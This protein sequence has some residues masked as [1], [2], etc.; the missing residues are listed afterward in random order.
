MKK[1]EQKKGEIVIYQSGKDVL[2]DVVFENETVW[3]SLNQIAKLFGR[4]KS[5]ISRHLTYIFREN[6]LDKKSVVA[7]NATTASDGK[8]YQ[9]EYYNLDAI[10]SVGYRVSS[11]QATQFRV[12]A[13]SVLRDHVLKGYTINEKRIKEN[14]ALKLKELEK[15]VSLLQG[16][17]RSRALNQAQTEGLLSVITDYASSWVLLQQY[18][19]G[20]T[21]IKK[22]KT[23]GISTIEEEESIEVILAL[24]NHL[25]KKKES[26]DIFG[27]ERQKGAIGGILQSIRQS[28]GGKEVY[29][30][31]EEKA[32]HLLYFIIKQHPLIDGNKRVASLLFIFFL[33]KNQHLYKKNGE[34]K[35][36][37]NALVALALLIAESKP[38][39]KEVMVSLVTNLLVE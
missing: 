8:T 24:K 1:D 19:A 35:V 36:N 37:D 14:Q 7:K 39:E 32:A 33:S 34:R 15:T 26:S 29:L 30:S 22:G 12:W 11:K 23:K 2:M 10:L 31:L 17:I 4:D 5:V 25:E 27:V 6:E 18:D 3:L 28:F 16:V 20:D 21:S 9:V 13:T 38:N